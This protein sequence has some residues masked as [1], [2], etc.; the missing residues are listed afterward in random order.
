MKNEEIK[1]IIAVAIKSLAELAER[2]EERGLK[3]D[4]VSGNVATSTIFENLDSDKWLTT[5]EAAAFLA[6]SPKCLLKECS[7]GKLRY[8]KFGRRNRF[9][10]SDLKKLLKSQPR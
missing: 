2:L 6:I 10:E 9:L 8:Y 5:S 1:S 7:N 4:A 3:V